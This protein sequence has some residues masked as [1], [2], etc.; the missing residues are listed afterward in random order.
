VL[1][2]GSVDRT[3]TERDVQRIRKRTPDSL[4]TGGLI[5]AGVG[6]ALGGL[7][8]SFSENCSYRS[9]SCA[10]PFISM[11][12]MAAGIGIGIDALIQG[13]KVIYEGGSRS[14][15]R[16]S[17]MPVISPGKAAAVVVIRR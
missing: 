1:A 10:G 3:F 16:V 15:S 4:W 13:R 11:T 9:S 8:V 2:V 17:V 5:G 7:A 14:S 6:A 12:A